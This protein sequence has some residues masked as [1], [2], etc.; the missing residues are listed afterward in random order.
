MNPQRIV[1][2]TLAVA[3]CVL[4]L[5]LGVVMAQSAEQ[6]PT[7]PPVGIYPS[8]AAAYH[9]VGNTETPLAVLV[10]T[11]WCVCC[12]AARARMPEMAKLAAVCHLDGERDRSLVAK[13]RGPDVFP[14]VHLFVHKAG[15][16]SVRVLVGT[17]EIAAWLSGK[18]R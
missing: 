17:E 12:P 13:L 3:A 2:W 15:H 16:W 7:P 18:R 8:Y 9:A 10:C 4:V 5:F 6:I 1:E 14:R 11:D